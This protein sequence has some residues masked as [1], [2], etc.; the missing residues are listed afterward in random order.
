MDALETL[1]QQTAN[2]LDLGRVVAEHAWLSYTQVYSLDEER[3]KKNPTDWFAVHVYLVLLE[4]ILSSKQARSRGSGVTVSSLLNVSKMHCEEF[5]KKLKSTLEHKL[6]SPLTSNTVNDLVRNYVMTAALYDKCSRIFSDIFVEETVA[7]SCVEPNYL[8]LLHEKK[9]TVW[10]LYLLAK[11]RT[12]FNMKELVTSFYA[13]LCC[14]IHIIQMTPKFLLKPQWGTPGHAGEAIL[15]KLCT[16]YQADWNDLFIPMFRSR[17][18]TEFLAHHKHL[19]LPA[20][21][22]EWQTIEKSLSIDALDFIESPLLMVPTKAASEEDKSSQVHPTPVQCRLNTIQHMKSMVVDVCDEPNDTI[23]KFFRV[24]EESPEERILLLLNELRDRY[25]NGHLAENATLPTVHMDHASKQNEIPLQRFAIIRKLYLRVLESLLKL[26]EERLSRKDFSVLLHVDTFHRS[27]VTCCALVVNHTYNEQICC[28][29]ALKSILEMFGIE[30]YHMCKVIECFIK[31]E[32][33]LSQLS[34]QHLKLCENHI[35]DNLA[36]KPDSALFAVLPLVNDSVDQSDRS[37]GSPTSGAGQFLTPTSRDA[38]SWPSAEE[39]QS[40]SSRSLDMFMNKVC[41]LAYHRLQMFCNALTIPR[42]V[43][44]KVWTC[45]EYCIKYRHDL[46]KGRHLDQIIMCSLYAICK[47]ID[48]EVKFKVIVAAHEKLPHKP[49]SSIYKRVLI[50]PPVGTASIIKFYNDVYMQS[51]KAYLLQFTSERRPP[52][53]PG[54]KVGHSPH[55]SSPIRISETITISPLKSGVQ[56]SPRT[57][58]LYCFN[59]Y[60]GLK[61]LRTASD[62]PRPLAPA[63]VAATKRLKFDEPS[64]EA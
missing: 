32:P 52:P 58:L 40:V 19:S 62:A 63:P 46:L 22:K 61:K 26:E 33:G 18:W 30:A 5:L 3:Y 14:F 23:L 24:C 31:A 57:G 25:V 10:L 51:M 53:S 2:R 27:L 7:V 45:L 44:P 17:Q 8:R 20:L 16:D 41:R 6:P 48:K 4:R 50:G 54:P 36:W 21:V 15:R 59:G 29:D 38:H 9:K 55:K 39:G 11:E 12:S 28:Y 60:E 34:V 42:D 47:V 37:S 64:G 13:L 1:F 43:A 56:M 49:D 35:L